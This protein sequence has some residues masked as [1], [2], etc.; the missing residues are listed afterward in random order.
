MFLSELNELEKN[1][2]LDLCILVAKAN[3]EL[4]IEEKNLIQAYCG[5]MQIPPR[6]DFSSN[7]EPLEKINAYFATATEHI[8][9]IVLLELLGLTYADSQYD[10]TE[11]AF[12]RQLA[13][14]IQLSKDT[15]EQLHHSI[16]NYYEVCRD[17]ALLVQ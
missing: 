2:F 17:L 6:A 7:L 5:E 13:E 11:D 9:K 1:Y 15:Y 12:L 3:N 14:N 10:A 4:A 8:K 16:R